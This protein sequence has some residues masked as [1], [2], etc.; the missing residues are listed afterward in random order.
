M[1]SG[2]EVVERI[3][4]DIELLEPRHCEFAVLDVGMVRNNIDFGVEFAGRFFRNL[5]S[6]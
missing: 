1:P 2:V 4:D 5:P 6:C 3:E